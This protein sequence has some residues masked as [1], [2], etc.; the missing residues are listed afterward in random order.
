M[1]VLPLQLEERQQSLMV[2]GSEMQSLLLLED[3]GRCTQKGCW[4]IV[5]GLEELVSTTWSTVHQGVE[6]TGKY[7]KRTSQLRLELS[8]GLICASKY[9]HAVLR[10]TPGF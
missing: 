2:L 7:V 10:R 9:I 5:W 1:I 4:H 3:A 6:S 8:G